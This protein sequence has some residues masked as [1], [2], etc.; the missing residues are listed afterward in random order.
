MKLDKK[1]HTYTDSGK[2]RYY[3]VS[4]VLD[5]LEPPFDP[6]GLIAVKVAA[7]EGCTVAEIQARWAKIG[8][9]SMNRGT[10]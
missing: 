4:H 2:K 8:Q 6:D 7:R 9:D 1:T 10:E 5:T 3:S